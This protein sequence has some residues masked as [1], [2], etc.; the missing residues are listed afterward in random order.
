MDFVSFIKT[1]VVA[2]I[3]LIF[4]II[5]LVEWSKKLGLKGSWLLVVSMLIGVVFGAAYLITQQRP[6]DGVDWWLW[7]QYVFSTIVYGCA[8]GLMASGLYDMIKSIIEGA[9]LKL[10]E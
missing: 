9:V 2:G 10:K 1:A 8:L 7:F 5:G 3:P 6:P 4:V